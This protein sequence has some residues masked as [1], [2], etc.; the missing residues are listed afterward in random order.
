MHKFAF[1]L[2][3]SYLGMPMPWKTRMAYKAKHRRTVLQRLRRHLQEAFSFPWE[4]TLTL[5]RF[6]FI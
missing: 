1:T 4:T 6:D 5:S 2:G 3:E